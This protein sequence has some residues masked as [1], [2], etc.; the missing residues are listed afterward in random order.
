MSS[1]DVWQSCS[2]SDVNDCTRLVD[3]E[4]STNPEKGF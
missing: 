1:H 4:L 3:D 2:L